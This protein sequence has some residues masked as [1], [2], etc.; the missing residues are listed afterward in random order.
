MTDS[1]DRKKL[2][3]QWVQTQQ[4]PSC[5]EADLVISKSNS[6]RKRGTKELLT[7]AEM[8]KREIPME[9]IRAIVA[10]GKGVPD[11][12][13]PDIPSLTRFWINTSTCEIDE[14]ET[15]QEQRVVVQCDGASALDGVFSSTPARA[16]P[17]LGADQMQ[18]ILEGLKGAPQGLG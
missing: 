4:D 6:K 7:T 9:K 16:A 8:I 13:C 11:E 3:Q 14:D 17:G 15:K 18:S 5:I 10:R 1:Q 12:D 2:L